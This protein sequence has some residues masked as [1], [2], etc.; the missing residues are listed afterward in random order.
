MAR[1]T[2]CNSVSK[3]IPQSLGLCSECILTKPDKTLNIINKIHIRC[4]T[5]FG[6]PGK[7]PTTSNGIPC[8]LCVH[9]CRIGKTQAGYCGLRKNID[10]RLIGNDPLKGKL[11]WYHDPLPT[12]CVGDWICPGGTGAGY[13]RYAYSRNAEYGYTNFAVFFHACSFDCL[14]CQNWHFKDHTFNSSYIDVSELIENISTTTSCICFFGGD[15]SPQLLFSIKTA[16]KAI[17]RYS[18]RILRICW[19]TNGSMNETLLDRIVDIALISGG[20]IKFDLKAW[21]DTLHMALTGVSN[22]R[23]LKNFK[24]AGSKIDQT[25]VC[26]L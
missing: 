1:C 14:Y 20:C 21:D 24:R 13:P 3:F 5:K 7:A 2:L 16:E 10:G 18:D 23:T 22:M 8:K 26:A 19:E 15:P 17:E 12:N 9:Q 4:R 6:L 11:G 25:W